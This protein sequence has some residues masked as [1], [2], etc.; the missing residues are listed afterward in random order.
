MMR[1]MLS[2]LIPHIPGLPALLACSVGFL[3]LALLPQAAYAGGPALSI[4]TCAPGFPPGSFTI[5][6]VTCVQN[7]VIAATIGMMGSVA[8]VMGPIASA[9]FTLAFAV[10]G[11]RVVSG[12]KPGR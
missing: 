8:G 1:K 4:D 12:E 3:A 7:S 5:K 2:R 9:L 10:F 6:I 11:I